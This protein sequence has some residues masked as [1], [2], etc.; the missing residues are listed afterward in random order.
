MKKRAPL[1]I[2]YCYAREDKVFRDAL[3]THLSGLK[4]QELLTTWS[5]RE[6]R[7]GEEWKLAVDTHIQA[8]H[9][10]LCLVSPDFLASNYC[11]EQEMQQALN[12]HKEGSA[13]V[14]PILVRP[15]YWENTPLSEL[16]MLPSN[17]LAVIL[18]PQPDAAW[19]DVIKSILPVIQE[20]SL[21]LKTK[22]EWLKEGKALSNRKQFEEALSAYEQAIQLDPTNS[23]T[24]GYKSYVLNRLKRYLEALEA[25]E[26]AIQLDPT[27]SAAFG[28]KSYA[29]EKL[30]QDLEA[31]EAA[32]RAIQ[33]DPTNS[34]AFEC[35][36]MALIGL[37]R[38]LEAL[39]A[40]EQA[41][42][43]SPNSIS[44]F[45]CKSYALNRLKRYLEALEAAERAIQLD[46]A[47]HFGFLCKSHALNILRRHPEVA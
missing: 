5:D 4:R 35:K 6:I 22:E 1:H 23:A 37:E 25:A 40:V 27:N 32:E 13:R 30:E 17:A 24:F 44:A 21:S 19:V 43:Y 10:I 12:R 31:L 9:I 34:T 20:L 26:R 16:Q 42:Q 36:S 8:A 41:I 7:P 39:D 46:P 2:F 3:D 33:L 28:Y 45:G 15:T 14:V 29:L 18:W 47:Y 38:Y 11:Y